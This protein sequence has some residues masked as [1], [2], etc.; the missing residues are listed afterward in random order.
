[1]N[2]R[3]TVAKSIRDAFRAVPDFP[4]SGIKFRDISP[5]LMNTKLRHQATR[6]LFNQVQTLPFNKI[7]ALDARG[8]L[9]GA[10]LA[11]AAA[12]AAPPGMPSEEACGIVMVRK[13]G[14][15][16]GDVYSTEYDLEYRSNSTLEIPVDQISARD[17]FLL[18][19]DVCAT[20]GTLLAAA[21]LIA[22]GGGKVVGAVCYIELSD[23]KGREALTKAGIPLFTLEAFSDTKDAEE[24]Q[25]AA[26][27]VSP[28]PV[29]LKPL[30][31]LHPYKDNRIIVLCYKTMIPLG[32]RLVQAF[33]RDF[34]MEGV[35]WDTFPDGYYN[36]RFPSPI[37]LQNRRVLFIGSMFDPKSFMEQL[38]MIMVL[39]R[40]F[41]LSLDVLFPWFGP[42]T[43][44]R[45]G[46]KGELAQELKHASDGVFQTG[47]DLVH[48]AGK[49]KYPDSTI[50]TAECFAYHISAM[51]PTK[52]GPPVIHIVDLHAEGTSF[53]FRDQVFPHVFSAIPLLLPRLPAGC[54]LLAPDKGSYTRMILPDPAQSALRHV[55]Q[56]AQRRPAHRQD[57]RLAPLQHRGSVGRRLHR[58]RPDGDRRH[59]LGVLPGAKSA[60]REARLPDD[61]PRRLSEPLLPSLPSGRGPRRL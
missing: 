36:I 8:F 52:E 29:L 31:R 5:L 38:A 42:G 28:K 40:Q 27:V 48:G 44:K 24:K 16:P 34:S 46:Q 11:N 7:A 21:K 59:R 41:L 43:M 56:G 33:P 30:Q 17:K 6:L 2:P 20:A 9:L 45:V 55:Q 49:L 18:V 10:E 54:I 60:R 12:K 3:A 15:L 58:G 47:D 25:Q 22:K 50:A 57:R 13:G 35:S 51:P 37:H 39:P 19:D 4:K 61:H 14:K 26:A 32:I 1:M 23:L 53:N